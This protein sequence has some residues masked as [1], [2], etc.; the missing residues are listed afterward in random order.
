LNNE[1]DIIVG[2]LGKVS[3]VSHQD[4]QPYEIQKLYAPIKSDIEMFYAK[5]S[6]VANEEVYL[7]LKIKD[8]EIRKQNI[9]ANKSPTK[10]KIRFGS[11][12]PRKSMHRPRG[13]SLDLNKSTLSDEYQFDDSTYSDQDSAVSCNSDQE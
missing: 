12:S 8:D 9:H 3:T 5:K 1:G 2:H 11:I 10:P 7:Q 4:Y 13:K 6:I